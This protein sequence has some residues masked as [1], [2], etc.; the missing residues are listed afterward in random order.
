MK[1]LAP[2]FLSFFLSLSFWNRG[3]SSFCVH[4]SWQGC[5]YTVGK[6]TSSTCTTVKN[7]SPTASALPYLGKM[8]VSRCLCESG[9]K[10]CHFPRC[11]LITKCG[12]KLTWFNEQRTDGCCH[13]TA[14]YLLQAAADQF[15][16]GKTSNIFFF[17]CI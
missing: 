13:V 6:Q 1:T 4:L 16:A 3:V 12:D 5:I 11:C 17:F 8:N 2:V 9:W 10:S 15:G 7:I 14:R